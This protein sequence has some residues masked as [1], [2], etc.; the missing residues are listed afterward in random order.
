MSTAARGVAPPPPRAPTIETGEAV[1]RRHHLPHHALARMAA[2]PL[3]TTASAVICACVPSVYMSFGCQGGREAMGGLQGDPKHF[4]G[5]SGQVP[6][7][8]PG[9][10][11]PVIP[12]HSA[13]S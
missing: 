8:L 3:A 12:S 1:G 10:M 2:V 6:R 4:G 9:F 13:L 5:V 7:G 11:W